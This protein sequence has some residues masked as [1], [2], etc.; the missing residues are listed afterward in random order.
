MSLFLCRIFC[1][2]YLWIRAFYEVMYVQRKVL[3]FSIIRYLSLDY[4]SSIAVSSNVSWLFYRIRYSRSNSKL[5]TYRNIAGISQQYTSIDIQ[6]SL[7]RGKPF[8]L[9][10]FL[11]AFIDQ[12]VYTSSI[13]VDDNS[14]TIF[15]E[16]DWA[17]QTGLRD[18]MSDDETSTGTRKASI[19][20]K[21]RGLG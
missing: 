13:R 6:L 20:D 1:T 9:A 12:P 10:S 21:S 16:S 14:V 17:S 11:F 5:S 15:Y 2:S 3:S 4:H 19:S 8:F 18:D 7:C